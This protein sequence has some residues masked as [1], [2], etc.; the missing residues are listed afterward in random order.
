MPAAGG[1]HPGRAAL[2]PARASSSGRLAADLVAEDLRWAFPG[3]AEV[4]LRP[5]AEQ[6]PD[7]PPFGAPFLITALFRRPAQITTR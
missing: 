7:S 1:T 6:P 2:L 4:E 3:L 5:M